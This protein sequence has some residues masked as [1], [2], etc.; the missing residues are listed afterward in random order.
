MPWAGQRP[1]SWCGGATSRAASA[2]AA[3]EPAAAP[4]LTHRALCMPPVWHAVLMTS[5]S[6]LRGF[7]EGTA[8]GCISSIEALSGLLGSATALFS[9]EG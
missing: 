3:P 9:L 2:S 1:G 7:P 4:P 8:A 5:L 6:P